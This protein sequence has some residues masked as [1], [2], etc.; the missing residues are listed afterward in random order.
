M[1][2]IQ[3]NVLIHSNESGAAQYKDKNGFRIWLKPLEQVYVLTEK[4]LLNLISGVAFDV[5]ENGYGACSVT[6]HYAREFLKKLNNQ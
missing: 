3:Q 4:D 1:K 5:K 2:L 6:R